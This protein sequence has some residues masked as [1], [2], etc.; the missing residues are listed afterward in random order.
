MPFTNVS[1]AFNKFEDKAV[2]EASDG[3]NNE[4]AAVRD[5][6]AALDRHIRELAATL[7]IMSEDDAAKAIAELQAIPAQRL[8]LMARESRI[9]GMKQAL[10][11]LAR[12]AAV[13][14]VAKGKT[15]LAA[16][17]ARVRK[18]AAKLGYGE[19]FTEKMLQEDASY[20]TA[21]SALT[22]AK[23]ESLN[24]NC[25]GGEDG[26][27]YRQLLERIGQEAAKLGGNPGALIV[28]TGPQLPR[29][30]KWTAGVPAG[31]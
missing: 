6:Y 20:K 11:P 26:F 15:D 29:V 22:I 25:N 19:S 17:E 18:A 31:R 14:A 1:A 3:I 10:N 16:A 23:R 5:G 24:A 8:V 13:R 30:E 7:P 9:Y 21:R 4:I 2:A 28:Q 27:H 12:A